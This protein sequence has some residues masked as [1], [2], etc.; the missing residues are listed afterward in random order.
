MDVIALAYHGI[1]TSWPAETTVTPERLEA[2]LTHLVA[3]GYRG[4][5]F[6][7]ALTVPP[8][9]RT[10]AVTFDDAHR[11]VLEL[12]LPIMSRLGL[13]GTVFVPTAF[14]EGRL[15]DWPGNAQ[16]L[17]GPHESE[18]R[19]MTWEEL[20]GLAETGWEIGSHTSSHPRLTQV[21][22][23]TLES[24]LRESREQCEDELGRPCHSL[25]YP[26]SDEDDRVVW[27]ARDAGYHFAAT[28]PRDVRAP[29]PLRWPRVGVYNHNT[30]RRFRIRVSQ[31]MRVV[32][33]SSAW[34]T[35][36]RARAL[37]RRP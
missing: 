37:V 23:A 5:T 35:L 15:M 34:R 11:S 29:L 10:V 8:A 19:C 4:A 33:G 30:D 21:A 3:Q 16:W 12:A 2:Q 14:A 20:R 36:N 1:S 28:I 7:A 31:R 24:E 25:A 18:L 27:A 6:S 32:R 17:D 22:D 13:V 9:A 26:Y